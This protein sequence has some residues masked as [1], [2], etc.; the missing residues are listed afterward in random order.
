MDHRTMQLSE[1]KTSVDRGE[2]EVD[3]RA[4][5]DAILARLLRAQKECS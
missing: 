2:Y 1:I 4:V 5:A 3:P